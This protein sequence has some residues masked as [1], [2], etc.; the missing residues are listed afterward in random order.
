MCTLFR[1]VNVGADNKDEVK[2]IKLGEEE[3]KYPCHLCKYKARTSSDLEKHAFEK[4][5]ANRLCTQVCHFNV[6]ITP[7]FIFFQVREGY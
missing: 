6:V 2:D 4:H 3:I 7:S 1:K 5:D